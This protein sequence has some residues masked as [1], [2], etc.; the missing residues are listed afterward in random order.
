MKLFFKQVPEMA[1]AAQAH[2]QIRVGTGIMVYAA[3]NPVIKTN[4]AG[5]DRAEGL[6]DADRPDHALCREAWRQAANRGLR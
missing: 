3:T 6:R 5:L 4:G 1:L 2:E